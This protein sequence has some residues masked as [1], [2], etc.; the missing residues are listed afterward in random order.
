MCGPARLLALLPVGAALTACTALG[1]LAPVD[2]PVTLTFEAVPAGHGQWLEQPEISITGREG[3]VVVEARM[4]TPDPCRKFEAAA[5]RSGGGVT[6]SVR[7]E[8]NSEGCYGVVGTFR[9]TAALSGLTPGTHRLTITHYL[10]ETGEP[11]PHTVFEGD[12]L[13]R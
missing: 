4:S 7:V 11:G 8:P 3:G 6:L 2:D 12:V 5:T 1:L 10:A 9:Y 13:V